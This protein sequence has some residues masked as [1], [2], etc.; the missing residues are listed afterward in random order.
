M[1]TTEQR[2]YSVSELT[3]AIKG[4]L[5]EQFTNI[6]VEGE[7]S[8]LATPQSGHTYFTLKDAS[9]QIRAVIFKSAGKLLKLN[10]VEPGRCNWRLNN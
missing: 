6:W 5:E 1:D 4:E 3:K 9:S 2:V 7:I 8:N 10:P